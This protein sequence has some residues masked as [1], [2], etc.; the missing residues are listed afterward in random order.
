[1][2]AGLRLRAGSGHGFLRGSLL[3][4]WVSASFD[5][6]T[7]SH[8]QHTANRCP[9][10]MRFGN[11]SRYLRSWGN[12][13]ATKSVIP[14]RGLSPRWRG[15]SPRCQ[16]SFAD[17]LA[18]FAGKSLARLSGENQNLLTAKDAKG[19]AKD[20]KGHPRSALD[21]GGKFRTVS[22]TLARSAASGILKDCGASPGPCGPLEAEAL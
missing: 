3:F 22:V 10:C 21:Q 15:G 5:V 8:S 9:M 6:K 18:N 19:T 20:A 1:M 7:P 17:F 14:E 12:S 16:T 13:V 4:P 11:S 2:R